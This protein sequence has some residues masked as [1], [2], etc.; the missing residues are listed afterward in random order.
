MDVSQVSMLLTAYGVTASIAAW[1]S[2]V[3]VQ[4][5]GPRK[6]MLAGMLAF[7]LGS[8]GFIG[9]GVTNLDMS[10]MLPF[11]AI[12]GLGYPLFAYSF[13]V[14]INYSTLVHSRGRAASWFWFMFSLGLSVIGPFYS[15][16]AIPAL[17]NIN[18]LWSGALF[19]MIGSFLAIKVNKDTVDDSEIHKFNI[20]EL[21][22]GITILQR[23]RIAIGL[24]VKT[25]NGLA[26]YGL[27]IFMPLYLAEFGFTT[28]EWLYMW[29]AVFSVAIFANLFFG[30]VGDKIGWRNTIQWVGGIAYAAVLV[31]LYYA[32]QL[33]G[34]NFAVVTAAIC[35]CG[36]TM[37]GYVPL[38]ALFPMLAPDNKGAA[39]SILNLGAGLSVFVAPAI[40]GIA[41]PLVG[42][43]GVLFIY[44]GFYILSA[45]LTPLL[46]TPEELADLKEERGTSC[47]VE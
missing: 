44:A 35:L 4:T 39:M 34:H 24:V 27:A 16:L 21:A 30:Y 17:G 46:K 45:I 22:K 8:V 29:S 13:L 18:V 15:S 20:Q 26:Q 10:V 40:A 23:P 11:Y 41:Y 14:W 37:A 19:V 12:R 31:L 38:S 2:G 28:N 1:M 25:I 42:A 6:V 32:P 43:Q 9:F 33:V 7:F 3:L 5:L 36:V 47:S